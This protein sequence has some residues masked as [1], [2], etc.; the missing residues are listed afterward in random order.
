MRRN[1]GGRPVFDA[2]AVLALLQDEPGADVLRRLQGEAIVN[3]VNAAEVLGKLVSRGF[4][5]YD[6]QA[7]L[8]ALHL[9]VEAFEPDMAAVSA[10]FVHKGVS[11][12]DR[13]FLA[14][15][16]RHGSGWTSDHALSALGSRLV[17]LNFF[18]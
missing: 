8:E 12:G 16:R 5:V 18:R 15:A 9:E 17:S 14:S 4:P 3:A 1:G 10:Q 13:C 11:L 6:A 2:T 7:A